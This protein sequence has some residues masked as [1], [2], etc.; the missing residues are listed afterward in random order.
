MK[1]GHTLSYHVES[2]P[3]ECFRSSYRVV[4][5]LDGTFRYYF[6]ISSITFVELCKSVMSR[7]VFLRPSE[8]HRSRAHLAH[9]NNAA[10]APRHRTLSSIGIA[11]FTR[12]GW[13]WR[14]EF[15]QILRN[16]SVTVA[17]YKIIIAVYSCARAGVHT[18]L[19]TCALCRIKVAGNQPDISWFRH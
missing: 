3:Q 8:R 14:G 16:M 10:D 7:D 4:Q 1:T 12:I 15:N 5:H 2:I 9:L 17:R 6:R 11:R 19:C 13:R 18:S